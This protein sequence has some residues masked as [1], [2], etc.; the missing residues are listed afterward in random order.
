MK[1]ICSFVVIVAAL[2]GG[3]CN[4]SPVTPSDLQG[5]TWRLVSLQRGTAPP[6]A[7]DDPSRYTIRLLEEGRV[8]V[9][10]DCNTCGGPYSGG[11]SSISIGPL[12]CTKVF[13]G[14]ASLDQE[15]VTALEGAASPSRN[16]AELVLR[17]DDVT[18]R[19]QP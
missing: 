3:A 17:R 4:D 1:T 18:L 13:C 16:D 5:R 2:M 14:T 12:A 19:F 9:K 6:T 11:D 7:I 10:S 8:A 15:F